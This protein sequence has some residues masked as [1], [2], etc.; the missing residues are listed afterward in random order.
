MK[1]TFEVWQSDS[2]FI[3]ICLSGSIG[4]TTNWKLLGI[5]ELEI[6]KPK[7]KVK[8]W[9]WVMLPED[10]ETYQVSVKSYSGQDEYNSQF[11]GTRDILVQKIDSTEIE[12]E[13]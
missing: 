10:K 8:K 12:V 2:G 1:Q 11:R 7:K 5:T 6:I 3:S 4:G 9:K 13:E